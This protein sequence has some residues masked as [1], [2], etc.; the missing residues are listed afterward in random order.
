MM[1]S[2]TPIDPQLSCPSEESRRTRVTAPV[3]WCVSMIL[4]L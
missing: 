1:F 2:E 3:P 4:T